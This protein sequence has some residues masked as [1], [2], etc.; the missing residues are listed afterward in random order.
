MFLKYVKIVSALKLEEII[1][2]IAILLIV[3]YILGSIPNGIWIGKVF[4]NTD[5]REHGSGNIGTTNTFRVLGKIPGAMVM[6]LDI[7]KGTL[8]T[9]LPILFNINHISPIIFGMCAVIGHTFSVFDHF[10]G[11]K[12]VATSAGMLLA[13]HPFLFV[14][15]FLFELTFTYLTSMVS[16]ASMISFPLITILIFMNHD[17]QLGIIGVILSI[18]I[19]VRHIGNI[20]RILNGDE[21]LM[22]FGILY[23]HMHKN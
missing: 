11:G 1:L 14:C 20:K 17:L 10:H 16:L 2:K 6:V 13:L 8:A 19:I 9:L 21:N 7:L 4:F 12:A 15:A 22:P 23:K 3:A 5:I 18:F